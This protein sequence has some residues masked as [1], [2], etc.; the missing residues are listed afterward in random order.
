MSIHPKPDQSFSICFCLQ[1][2]FPSKPF[3][4]LGFFTMH[5][6][7]TPLHYFPLQ[8]PLKNRSGTCTLL[9]RE[10]PLVLGWDDHFPN[11]CREMRVH[12]PLTVQV[13]LLQQDFNIR[14]SCSSQ[15]YLWFS[16]PPPKSA[17]SLRMWEKGTWRRK[18]HIKT[19][20]ENVSRVHTGY[21]FF[22]WTRQE[23][24]VRTGLIRKDRKD[25][26]IK[27]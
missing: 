25:K 5:R 12:C 15:L 16:V 19:D 18:P 24:G 21:F 20:W 2:T 11:A 26:E 10:N 14:P 27:Y 23:L 1:I 6:N 22:Y 13:R 17:A 7:L 8:L 4:G 9:L 3:W